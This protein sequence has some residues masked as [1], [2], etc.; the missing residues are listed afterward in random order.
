VW[1]TSSINGHTSL[2]V[3]LDDGGGYWH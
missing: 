2:R 1:V 3:V